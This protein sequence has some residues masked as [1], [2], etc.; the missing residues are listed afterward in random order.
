MPRY[1]IE[2][3]FDRI[4]DDDMLAGS[5]R[6]DRIAA[7]RFPEIVW[8][9]SHRGRPCSAS[10]STSSGHRTGTGCPRSTRWTRGSGS[11]TRAGF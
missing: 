3:F 1:V 8:E 11:P 2:R 6:S 5:V 4:T 9:H 10:S 7:E